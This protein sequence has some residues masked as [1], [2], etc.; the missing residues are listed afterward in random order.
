[1]K[2]K[3]FTQKAISESEVL[4]ARSASNVDNSVYKAAEDSLKAAISRLELL[5]V[6]LDDLEVRAPFDGRVVERHSDLGEWVACT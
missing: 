2:E 3:L 1:M 4:D 5:S 6:R